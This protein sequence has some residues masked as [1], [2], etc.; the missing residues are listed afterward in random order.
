MHICCRF[1]VSGLFTF[2]MDHHSFEFTDPQFDIGLAAQCVLN[3]VAGSEGF[4]FACTGPEGNIVALKSWQYQLSGSEPQDAEMDL[5]KVFGSEQ[6][7]SWPYADVRCAFFN[8]YATLT[9]RRM[10]DADH[11]PAYFN[12]LLPPAEYEYAYDVLPEFECF[13]VYA[14]PPPVFRICR[15]YFPKGRFMHLAT[16]FLKN[17]RNQAPAADYGLFVNLRNHTAQIAVFDRR[18]LV[19]YNTAPFSKPADLL[20]F[21]L[22]KYDLFRLDPAEVPL[23][24]SGQLSKDSDIYRLLYRYVRDIRFTGSA[25]PAGLPADLNAWPGHYWLDLFALAT[26]I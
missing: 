13:L 22:L 4:S 7:L 15:H 3:V 16:P 18:N 21:I 6:M 1:R 20:Y 12:L 26:T 5:R 10:F 9:P 23:H 8:A 24:I 2:S 25:L 14:V 17:V 11:L 19:F